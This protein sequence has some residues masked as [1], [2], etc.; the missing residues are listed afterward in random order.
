MVRTHLGYGSPNKQNTY[1]AHGSPLGEEEDKLTKQNL[2]WPIDPPFYIPDEALAHFR[3][4]NDLNK[5]KE[6]DWERLF[7]TYADKYP[8]LA[9][10]LSQAIRGDLPDNWDAELPKFPVEEKGIST[11]VA[12]GKVMNAIAA[13]VP[14]L[15]GGS[16]DLD[17]ST[18]TAL[19][20]TGDFE[21]QR[22]TITDAQG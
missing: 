20:G 1:E 8:G 17:P 19:G 4:D 9:Q 2:G 18:Y 22:Q 5:Q 11:R 3:K 15:M 13:R 12:S 21:S 14:A 16:A 10:E 7:S 6:T